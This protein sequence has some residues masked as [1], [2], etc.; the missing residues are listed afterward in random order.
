MVDKKKGPGGG[1]ILDRERETQAGGSYVL[2]KLKK[3]T[4]IIHIL[5]EQSTL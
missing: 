2:D 3:N 1:H 5:A 4:S